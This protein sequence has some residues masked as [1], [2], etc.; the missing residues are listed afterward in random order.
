MKVVSNHL[1]DAYGTSDR[2]GQR[3]VL[4]RLVAQG[5]VVFFQLHIRRARLA[6]PNFYTTVNNL[7]L[8]TI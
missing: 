7:G 8:E 2:R 1:A 3:S 5:R 4:S 6:Q